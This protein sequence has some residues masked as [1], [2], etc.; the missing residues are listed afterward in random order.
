MK[1]EVET[2]CP[3]QWH[4]EYESNDPALDDLYERA[5]KDQWNVSV[6][7]PWDKGLREDSDVFK[8]AETP[9]T[10]TKFFNSLSEQTQSDL[11]ANQAAFM[12]SHFFHGEQGALLCCGQFVDCVPNIEGKLYAATQVMDEARHV[13]VFHRYLGLLDKSYPI[14]GGLKNIIGGRIGA[15][16]EMCE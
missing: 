2:T 8:R 7:I 13:E 9:I 4:F 15:Y 10:R 14:V 12:L 3:T 5:K 16:T 1:L 11:L 6:D